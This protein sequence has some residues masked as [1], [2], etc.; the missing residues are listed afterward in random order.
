M[1]PSFVT[2]HLDIWTSAIE[3]KSASGRGRNNKISLY[4]IKKLRELIL[5]L[6]VRGKL[7]PQ[8]PNDEPASM[9]LEKIAAEK[10]RLI[11]EGK[12]KKPKKLSE[13]TDD[14]KPFDLPEGWEWTKL[15]NLSSNIHYGYTASAKPEGKGIRLLRITDIQN[16]RVNWGTVPGCEITAT[17]A[18][19]YLLENDDVL[20]ARTGGT[21][22]KSYLVENINLK[23][24]FA[25]YLIRVKKISAMYSPFIKKFLGSNTYWSQLY[26]HSSG[27][28]QPNVNATSLKSLIVPIPPEEEQHHIVA[29]VDELMSLCDQLE[30]QTENSIA[31]HQTLVETLL[32]T[33]SQSQNAEELTQNW[34]RISD[35]FDTL[36]TTEHSIDQLKQTILQLAVMGKLVPQD[37]NDE[38]ASVLLEN[39][40]AEKERLIKDKKIKKQKSLPEISED[41]KPFELPEGWKWIRMGAVCHTVADGP[42][43]SPKYVEKEEG[44]PFLSGRNINIDSIDLNTAKY[45]SRKDHEEFCRRVKPKLGDIL[46]TKGGTT[47]IAKVNDIDIEF[48]VWVHVAVL[49]IPNDKVYDEFLALALNCPHCYKQ[50]QKLTHG[51]GNKDLGL[52]RMI[53]ITI[54]F[55]PLEEQHRIVTKVNQLMMMCEQ[56]K[57]HITIAQ[58]TRLHLTDAIIE[59]A[60]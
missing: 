43:F 37:P 60:V 25:S 19:D 28:G 10:E 55:P 39:I 7:V 30:Q 21:I 51:I 17:K 4:G 31:A 14:E 42:H 52:T 44:I 40:A 2:D 32:N 24:V 56:I 58:T 54:P 8:D 46:Y 50:S 12:I 34:N 49:Q 35:H 47:G 57:N 1:K 13:V 38:P 29:K 27:T 15:G 22:G 9:L 36:F 59:Q 48:S 53:K 6:A 11:K 23:T 41:E 45:V 5:E 26:E 20:I 16:D 3:K 18:K 33:L